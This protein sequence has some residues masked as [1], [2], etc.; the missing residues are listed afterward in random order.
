MIDRYLMV[1]FVRLSRINYVQGILQS[2]D[3]NSWLVRCTG[4]A[5]IVLAVFRDVVESN[6]AN[7]A[8]KANMY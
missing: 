4:K 7:I 1:K 8:A 5:H 6:Q 2:Q 3:Y